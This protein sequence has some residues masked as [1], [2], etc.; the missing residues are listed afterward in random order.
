MASGPALLGSLDDLLD[1]Q[2]IAAGTVAQTRRPRRPPGYGSAS[3]SGVSYT[4]TAS[5]SNSWMAR[6]IRMAISPRLATS[7]F[8]FKGTPFS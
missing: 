2:I 7:I 6:M 8:F 1:V 5:Y 3:L 4:A